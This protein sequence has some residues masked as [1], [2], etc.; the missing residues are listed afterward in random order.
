MRAGGYGVRA[1]VRAVS[2]RHARFDHAATWVPVDNAPPCKALHV[3]PEAVGRGHILVGLGGGRNHVVVL[4]GERHHLGELPSGRWRVGPEVP[5]A[6]FVAWF[7]GNRATWVAIHHLVDQSPL[8]VLPERISF[9]HVGE[10]LYGGNLGIARTDAD[11]LGQLASGG[12][13]TWA[14]VGARAGFARAPAWISRHDTT[15]GKAGDVG[16]KRIT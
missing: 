16:I 1:E 8:Y 7:L 3:Y 12:G 4:G 14:E 2:R 6:D 5:A 15:A 9:W 10:R 13:P 11:H